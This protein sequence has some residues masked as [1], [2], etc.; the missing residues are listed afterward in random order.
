MENRQME[1]FNRKALISWG[2]RRQVYK[3]HI[4]GGVWMEKGTSKE[5]KE[6]TDAARGYWRRVPVGF[7]YEEWKA[8]EQR[9]RERGKTKIA[10]YLKEIEAQ[11]GEITAFKLEK[12]RELA[13]E[14]KRWQISQDLVLEAYRR[15]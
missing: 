5:E 12:A 1:N 8:T 7:T 11:Q 10:P 9:M 3:K 15:L 14:M 13:F 2:F 6:A 4:K